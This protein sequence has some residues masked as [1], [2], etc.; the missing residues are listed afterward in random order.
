MASY[1]QSKSILDG[2]EDL[3]TSYLPLSMGNVILLGRL[4][5]QFK[6]YHPDSTVSNSEE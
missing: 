1:L 6:K 2:T 4:T 5:T 3:Q